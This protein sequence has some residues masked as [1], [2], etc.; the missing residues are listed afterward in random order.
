M[1]AAMNGAL[2]CSIADGWW[3]EAADGTNGWVIDSGGRADDEGQQDRDDA[4]AL[5]RLLEE[6]IVPLYY[7]RDAAGLPG[8]WIARMKRSIATITPAFSSLR[9]VRDY[10]DRA[11]VPAAARD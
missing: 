2:N 7:A 1:K 4:L 3:P 5:Y 6:E 8:G 9:M 11:Y 10:C